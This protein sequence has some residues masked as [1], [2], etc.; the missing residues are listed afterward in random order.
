M[1]MK[2]FLLFFKLYFS[3]IKGKYLK[4][5]KHHLRH[6]VIIEFCPNADNIIFFC[7]GD[8]FKII[9]IELNL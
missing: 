7:I 6:F 2:F 3:I 8:Q 5:W 9:Y 1:K 4:N